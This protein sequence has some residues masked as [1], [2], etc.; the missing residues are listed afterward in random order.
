MIGAK[1]DNPIATN[2]DKRKYFHFGPCK[3]GL[4]TI[5]AVRVPSVIIYTPKSQHQAL[6]ANSNFVNKGGREE[7]TIAQYTFCNRGSQ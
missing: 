7:L 1:A 6:K 4:R 2:V 5:V 3:P